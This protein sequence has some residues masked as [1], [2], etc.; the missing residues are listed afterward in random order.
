MVVD[1]PEIVTK[2]KESVD[3][4]HQATA[5]LAPLISDLA[6]LNRGDRL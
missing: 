6:G 3:Q 4:K 1:H 2:K 5:I